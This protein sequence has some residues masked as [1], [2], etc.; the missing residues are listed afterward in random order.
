MAL[1]TL[2]LRWNQLEGKPCFEFWTGIVGLQEILESQPK[3]QHFWHHK[4]VWCV[5][6]CVCVYAHVTEWGKSSI[7][8]PQVTLVTYFIFPNALAMSV[9]L[10][11]LKGCWLWASPLCSGQAGW[12]SACNAGDPGSIPGLGRS[13][14]GGP[15]NPLQYSCLEN[16]H[17]QRSLAGYSPWGCRVGH[18]RVNNHSTQHRLVGQ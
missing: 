1:P 9:S 17:G 10:S 11:I 15:G 14:G 12:T 3:A 5:C 6:V 8:L 16:P 7:L 2:V 4:E 18:D 13:L